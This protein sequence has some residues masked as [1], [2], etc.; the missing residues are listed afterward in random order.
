M[1]VQHGACL[2]LACKH[3][4]NQHR[5]NPTTQR[6]Y[7]FSHSKFPPIETT[8]SA[9]HI[10]NQ[11]NVS[12][13][14]ISCTRCNHSAQPGSTTG[15]NLSRPSQTSIDL[16]CNCTTSGLDTMAP[17]LPRGRH[18]GWNPGE[19]SSALATQAS[20]TWPHRSLRGLPVMRPRG[21]GSST[22][23]RVGP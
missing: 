9:V 8:P 14:N 10:V 22:D 18:Y 6:C 13:V 3:V 20:N 11:V 2:H 15:P 23:G 1:S 4:L 19:L 16:T 5:R 17:F 21:Y 12:Y 7:G